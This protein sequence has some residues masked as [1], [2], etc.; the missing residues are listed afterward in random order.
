[1]QIHVTEIT[2]ENTL[3]LDAVQKGKARF[4]SDCAS[5]IQVC[6]LQPL[7]RLRVGTWM[8]V[9]LCSFNA[10]AYSCS[11]HVTHMHALLKMLHRRPTHS[12]RQSLKRSRIPLLF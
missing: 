3:L 2:L 4:V 10:R 12:I 9:V 8:L 5:Y 11:M 6:G 7:A 1:M